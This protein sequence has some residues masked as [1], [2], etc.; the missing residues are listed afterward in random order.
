MSEPAVDHP[1]IGR[2]FVEER[3]WQDGAFAHSILARCI[4]T[5]IEFDW[6]ARRFDIIALSPDFDP[7]PPGWVYRTYGL[8]LTEVETDS[9]VLTVFDGFNPKYG[10]D[11]ITRRKA[12]DVA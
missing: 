12:G 3:L 1:R 2:F 5:K 9:G 8:N 11:I 6:A 10:G 7:C 4:P